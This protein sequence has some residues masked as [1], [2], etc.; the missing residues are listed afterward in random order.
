MADDV[1]DPELY[2]DLAGLVREIGAFVAVVVAVAADY[3][4]F[5]SFSLLTLTQPDAWAAAILIDDF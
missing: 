3:R 4:L 1:D 2:H 5:G